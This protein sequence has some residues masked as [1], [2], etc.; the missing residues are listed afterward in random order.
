MIVR[1]RDIN[2]FVHAAG[3]CNKD[4]SNAVLLLHGFPDSSKLWDSQVVMAKGLQAVLRSTSSSTH[5]VVHSP[6][7]AL[8]KR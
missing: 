8:S 4:N 1:A 6:P 2:L 7:I 5:C 3:S